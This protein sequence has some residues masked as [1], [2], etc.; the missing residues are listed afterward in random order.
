MLC[1]NTF[2]NKYLPLF[3]VFQVT[4]SGLLV[5]AGVAKSKSS[6]GVRRKFTNVPNTGLDQY[7]FD[8]DM[9]EVAI[10]APWWSNMVVTVSIAILCIVF[11]ILYCQILS[12]K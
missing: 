4:R 1:V 10:I 7:N 5:A 11:C 3:T 9:S 2:I 12:Y 8:K 6:T